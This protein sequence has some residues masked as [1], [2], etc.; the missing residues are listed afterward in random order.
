MLHINL[1]PLK[2]RA[3]V[4]NVEKEIILFFLVHI[5]LILSV[6]WIQN[7]ITSKVK[8]LKQVHSQRT[9][10]KNK[11]L[12]K[13][14]KTN[15]LEK[16][17]SQTKSKIKIIKKIR[18]GQNLPVMYLNELVTHLIAD[19]IWFE[20]L[21]M[22]NNKNINLQGIALDNQ[23]F[24]QYAKN[25]RNTPV[26]KDIIL[27]QTARRN[28]RDLDLIGFQCRINTQSNPDTENDNG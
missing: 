13:L 1:L 22:N 10:Y 20:S 19:K 23:A 6:F 24:A 14:S 8:E 12:A 17:I 16:E 27:K 7:N 25:L 11:L 28:I 4:A 26:I 2:K 18:Q 3:K 5:L 21:K 15:K 9:T